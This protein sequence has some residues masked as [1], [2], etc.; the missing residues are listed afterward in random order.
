M[1]YKLIPLA[2]ILLS[3]S[4]CAT[5]DPIPLK[6]PNGNQGYTMRCSGM[7]RTLEMCYQK[8]G[9][10]CPNGYNIVGQDNSTVA[11]PINGSI[12]AAPQRNLT[13]ECK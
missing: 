4:S 9:E 2:S 8:A 10:V 5:I 1:N 12:I 7:G 6:G 13:I 11:V 3:L